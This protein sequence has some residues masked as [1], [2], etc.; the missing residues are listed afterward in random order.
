MLLAKTYMI[1]FADS[2][3]YINDVLVSCENSWRMYMLL[4]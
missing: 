3:A 2:F 1:D 4:M